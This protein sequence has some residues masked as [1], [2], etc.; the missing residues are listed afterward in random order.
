MATSTLRIDTTTQ[1]RL[2]ELASSRGESMGT[3]VARAVESL[4]REQLLQE[5]NAS[6]A[7]LREDPEAWAEELEERRLSENTLMDDLEDDE[8]PE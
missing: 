1:A 3:V 4:W 6:F 2:R 5:I 7:R 8:W